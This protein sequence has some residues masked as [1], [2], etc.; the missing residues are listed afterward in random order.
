VTI[1]SVF[2]RILVGVAGGVAWTVGLFVFFGPAQR[3]LAD[4]QL[5][6]GKMNAVF[7]SLQPLPRNIDQPWIVPLALVAIC[8]IYGRVYD[9]LLPVMG[10]TRFQ[11]ATRFGFL[12]WI[13]II[14]WFE[15]YLPW[16]V[17][18][19][20]TPLVLLEFA[21]WFLVMQLTAAAIT[22]T[23]TSPPI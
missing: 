7:Q 17:L 15:F 18:W 6:S 2:R 5:Q 19:E 11:R 20:P 21:L 23:S 3:I 22:L 8:T 1:H 13:M 14:P 12:L 4:P 9:W 16:N 10:K